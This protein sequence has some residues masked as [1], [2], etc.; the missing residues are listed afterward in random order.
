MKHE[1][2]LIENPLLNYKENYINNEVKSFKYKSICEDM[3]IDNSFEFNFDLRNSQTESYY[4]VDSINSNESF[5][6]SFEDYFEKTNEENEE[7]DKSS[8]ELYLNHNS[9]EQK[10]KTQQN[11]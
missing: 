4:S 8:T 1:N 10:L 7:I 11:Q 3:I 2:N 5:E 6:E 9:L